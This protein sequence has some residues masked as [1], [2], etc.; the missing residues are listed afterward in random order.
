MLSTNRGS[1]EGNHIAV[2][3]FQF[4]SIQAPNDGKDRVTRRLARSHAVKQALKNKRKL[5]QESRDNFRITTS[6]D[7]RGMLAGRRPRTGIM[8]M[9]FLSPSAGKLDPFET[10]A[11]DA[12]RLQ[13]LLNDHK[14]WQAPEPVFSVAEEAAFQSFRSVFRTG[15]VD[16]ALLNAVMLSLAFSVAGGSINRECLG[17]QGQ[18]ISYVRER[19]GSLCE[20][21]SE[22]T[23][24]A[25]LLLAGVEARLGMQSQVQLHM[26]AVR[27]LLDICQRENVN[28]NGGIKRAIFWQDLNSSVLAGSSRIVD[29]TTFSELEWTR[30]QFS[31]QFS[32][33]YFRLPSGFQMRSHLFSREFME[34]IEDL[35]ALQCVRDNTSFKK[36]D[37]TTMAYINNHTASIQSRLA[38]LPNPSGLVSCC[39]LA[40]YLCATMLCCKVWCALVIPL[41]VSSQLLGEL[42]KANNDPVWNNNSDLFLWLL[43][44][45]GA[46][47]PVGAVRSGYIELLRSHNISRR[48]ILLTSWPTL[49]ETMKRFIWS[50]KAF[51]THF[52][53]FWEDNFASISFTGT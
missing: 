53:A 8:A 44:I 49:L 13:A 40:T 26:G 1:T 42:Q 33:G 12:S 27:L 11:V 23:I 36:C 50:D 30:D 46:F 5:Q 21:T 47:S 18:T 51:M 6:Q 10:L 17:Y 38:C 2:G 29:H 52:K 24:G 34:V 9:S 19:M 4:I 39:R 28:L 31:H 20:A 7:T 43:Y 35:N 45:G 37:A 32:S 14:A 15:L 41:H 16:P 48:K 25:I 22:A 3:Q